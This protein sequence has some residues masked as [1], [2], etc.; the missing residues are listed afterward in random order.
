MSLPRR[1]ALLLI[2]LMVLTT[3]C[4]GAGGDALARLKSSGKIVVSTD[5][6][7]PPQSLLND[8]N[9]FEGFDID[10]ATEIAKRLG[11]KAEFL[12]TDFSAVTAGNW[13]NRWNMS[14]GSV[15]ITPERAEVL[16][17]TQPYYFTPAQMATRPDTGI[18]SIDGFAGKTVCVAETTTYLEWV[19]GTLKLPESAGDITPPPA[20]MK[21]TTLPTDINCAEAWKAGRND[22]DGWV[23]ASETVQDAIAKGFPVV[24]VGDPVFFE[25]L[26]V[27]FD[28]SV[29]D[30]DSLVKAVDDIIGKMHEDGTLTKLSEKWYD[31]RDLTTQ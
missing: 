21:A 22:A 6:N 13:A 19:N 12:V 17:F 24:A 27:A 18:T 20:G 29:K 15:T 4:Q 7:Y 11:V 28:K 8:K 26:G 2:G 10:V 9:Q 16:D 25:P 30:N 5:P 23:S 3:A 1:G 31:G 14:V